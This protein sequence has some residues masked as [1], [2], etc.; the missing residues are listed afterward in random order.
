MVIYFPFDVYPP[1]CCRGIVTVICPDNVRSPLSQL[2][3]CEG[4]L[5]SAG[6]EE[7]QRVIR[8]RSIFIELLTF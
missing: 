5:M 8:K 2:S 4:F 7:K 3:I 1:D 6:G